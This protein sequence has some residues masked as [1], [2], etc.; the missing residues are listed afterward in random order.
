MRPELVKN[1]D[2]FWAFVGKAG[3]GFRRYWF[4]TSTSVL[5]KVA[6][7]AWS[8]SRESRGGSTRLRCLPVFENDGVQLITHPTDRPVLLR[9]VQALIKVIRVKKI[10]ALLRIRCRFS[11]LL[12][13]AH[14]SAYRNE[15]TPQAGQPDPITGS[16]MGSICS[17]FWR[18]AAAC[19]FDGRRAKFSS[20]SPRN[21]LSHCHRLLFGG[22]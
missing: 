20:S 1:R 17:V 6:A 14:F 16:A 15:T 8:A 11:G 9:Q 13:S 5:H 19:R 3:D 12:A 18:N 7:P 10:L 22:R 2:T 4:P 21:R